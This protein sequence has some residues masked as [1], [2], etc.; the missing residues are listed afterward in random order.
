M[1]HSLT[2]PLADREAEGVREV[3]DL[4]DE[5]DITKEDFDIMMEVTKWPNSLD[6]LSALSSKVGLQS[7][8]ALLV[9]YRGK[10]SLSY[11]THHTERD[12]I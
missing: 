9:S 6:P 5:Y 11:T 4:M 12:L 7:L 2:Q 1:R 10:S 3:I 8:V